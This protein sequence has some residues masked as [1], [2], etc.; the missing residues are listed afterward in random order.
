MIWLH[1]EANTTKG[2]AICGGSAY[3]QNDMAIRAKAK[4]VSPWTKPATIAPIINNNQVMGICAD[5][6]SVVFKR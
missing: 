5:E 1:T 4:P 6:N 2:A 3:T